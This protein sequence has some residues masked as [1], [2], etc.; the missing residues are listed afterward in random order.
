MLFLGA[1]GVVCGPEGVQLADNRV[2]KKN[3]GNAIYSY[4]VPY[5]HGAGDKIENIK[6]G[7]ACSTYGGREMCVQGSG[8]E[9]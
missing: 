6:M 4:Q 8:G 3:S 9:A 1:E 2:L 7:G 5:M